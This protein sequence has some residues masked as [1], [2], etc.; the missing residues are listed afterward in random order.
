MSIGYLSLQITAWF[1]S[2]HWGEKKEKKKNFKVSIIK[3]GQ[4]I[5]SNW[6]KIGQTPESIG[7]PKALFGQIDSLLTQT[8]STDFNEDK[9]AAEVEE[10]Q[11]SLH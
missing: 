1:Y 5:Q 10:E 9:A 6:K 11:Q 2:I 3:I 4:N 7:K 8:M